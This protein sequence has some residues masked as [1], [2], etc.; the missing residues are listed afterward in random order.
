MIKS[1]LVELLC[2]LSSQEVKEFGEFVKSPFFNKND[3]VTALY[4]LLKKYYPSFDSTSLKKEKIFEKVYPGEKFKDSK[5]RLLMFYLYE[6]AKKY[7]Q[8]NSFNKDTA[9]SSIFLS[10]EMNE[11]GLLKEAEKTIN[12]NSKS[13][14]KI[15]YKDENYFWKKYLN[16]SELFENQERQ[17][18]GR[19]EKYMTG[20]ILHE[21][22]KNLT[23]YYLLRL[24]KLYTVVLNTNAMFKTDF[25]PFYYSNILNSFDMEFYKD[26]PILM[27]YYYAMK[28][29]E[30]PTNEDNFYNFKTLVLEQEINFDWDTIIDLYIN[31]ENY[32]VRRG[33]EGKHKFDRELFE[34]YKLEIEKKIYMIGKHMGPNFYKSTVTTAIKVNE[35]EWAEKFIEEFKKELIPDFREA[36]YYHCYSRI[37]IH[38][39]DYNKALECLSKVR[40][41]EVYLKT[42]SRLLFAMIY[43]ELGIE[44]SLHYLLDTMR[45]FFKNDRYL[46]EDRNAYYAYYVKFLNKLNSIRH[47][48]SIDD[49]MELRKKI[50]S[51]ERLFLKGW[52]LEKTYEVEKIL[53]KQ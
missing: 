49:L 19:Y 53:N 17:F 29:L 36:A 31:M 12:E 8:V 38:K 43:Y 20:E 14:N 39:K 37:F 30:N 21:L 52:L 6:C 35:P 10:R 15:L 26:K 18:A 34:I 1:N 22:P 47:K 42:E 46:A 32:C 25:D 23:D 44:D 4:N 13:L 24:M 40:T 2:T 11:R 41:D 33:R 3:K 27:A 9:F 45:H 7:L 50:N 16:D 28:M 51:V 48:G 5:L